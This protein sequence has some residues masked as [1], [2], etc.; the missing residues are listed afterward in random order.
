MP[1][2]LQRNGRNDEMAYQRTPTQQSLLDDVFARID[3][4]FGNPARERAARIDRI[5][6][7]LVASGRLLLIEDGRVHHCAPVRSEAA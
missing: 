3:A 6:D 7:K 2:R 5:A 1:E 4:E